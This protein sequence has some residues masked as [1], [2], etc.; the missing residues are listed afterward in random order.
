MHVYGCKITSVRVR[1]LVTM[2]DLV[3]GIAL[4]KM[5]KKKFL[6]FSQSGQSN[7]RVRIYKKNIC[8]KLNRTYNTHRR[9]VY[10]VRE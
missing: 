7:R 2:T 8:S 10:I 9:G 5:K 3:V 4:F 1:T 6:F